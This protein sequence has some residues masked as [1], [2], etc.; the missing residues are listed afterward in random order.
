MGRGAQPR[1]HNNC[2]CLLSAPLRRS[3]VTHIYTPLHLD[4]P[5]CG[6]STTCGSSHWPLCVTAAMLHAACMLQARAHAHIDRHAHT[7]RGTA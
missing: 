5:A 1:V 4:Q 7:T 2:C 3:P 6:P